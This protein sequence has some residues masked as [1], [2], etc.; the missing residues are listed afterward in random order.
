ML[1]NKDFNEVS[2]W[3]AAVLPANQKPGLKILA[4]EQFVETS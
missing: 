1:V 3:L 2:Y 4:S